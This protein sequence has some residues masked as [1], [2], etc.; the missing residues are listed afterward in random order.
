MKKLSLFAIILITLMLSACGKGVDFTKTNTYTLNNLSYSIPSVFKE[1][2]KSDDE[3]DFGEE[4]SLN[5]ASYSYSD[6]DHSCYVYL[7]ESNY[8]FDNY[9]EMVKMDLNTNNDSVY[10]T[11][12]INNISWGYGSKDNEYIYL[13]NYNKKG[14]MVTY[15]DTLKCDGVKEIIEN[16][17]KFN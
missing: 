5:S 3:Y 7:S 14:Y 15:S 9:K 11:K 1:N 4:Y 13:A 2:K 16:S 12:L 8:E 17:L 10:S 6:K